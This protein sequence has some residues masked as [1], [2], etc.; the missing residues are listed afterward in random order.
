MY[1][2]V[3]RNVLNTLWVH[4]G[5]KWG[6]PSAQWRLLCDEYVSGDQV[7]V[8]MGLSFNGRQWMATKYTEL[9]WLVWIWKG[10]SFCSLHVYRYINVRSCYDTVKVGKI[11]WNIIPNLGSLYLNCTVTVFV[12][13]IIIWR[14]C[15]NMERTLLAMKTWIN[16][17]I[18]GMSYQQRHLRD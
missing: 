12:S 18:R 15:S 1:R 10:Q 2:L 3:S 5:Q 16:M 9:A 14:M 4:C 11:I 6:N 17:A 13:C 8:S 7:N